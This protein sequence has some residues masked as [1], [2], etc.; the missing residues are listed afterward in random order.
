MIRLYVH[1]CGS[2]PNLPNSCIY[3]YNKMEVLKY[4]LL[5]P[6]WNSPKNL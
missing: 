1:G 3:I 2:L 6:K 4:K 5:A